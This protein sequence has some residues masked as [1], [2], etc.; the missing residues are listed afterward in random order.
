MQPCRDRRVAVTKG[1]ARDAKGR[2]PASKQAPTVGEGILAHAPPPD[3]DY[4][5]A[6]GCLAAV[7]AK[8][9]CYG[10]TPELVLR[11]GLALMAMGNYLAAA[12]DAERVLQTDATNNEAHYLHGEACLA[13]AAVKCGML[14]P[15]LAAA[16]PA[17]ALP[18]QGELLDA[19]QQAFETVLAGNP[20]DAQA[21]R[22]LDATR[23][24]R[25][26]IVQKSLHADAT[27]E[28]KL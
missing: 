23:R 4:A 27:T 9:N 17:A 21:Q 20:D 15:G 6:F 7:Q 16:H 1:D 14:R 11:R 25:D 10:G 26:Q 22:G 8:I 12:Y 13:L 5:A 24:L 2:E 18:T 3:F 19:A 28:A